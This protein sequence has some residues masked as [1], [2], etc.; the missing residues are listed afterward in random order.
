MASGRGG[1]GRPQPPWW[2]RGLP[3]LPAAAVA[4]VDAVT[5]DFGTGFWVCLGAVLAVLALESVSYTAWQAGYWHARNELWVSLNEAQL[6][7]L[8]PAEWIEAQMEKDMRNLS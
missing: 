3:V 5:G 1:P 7:G 8:S 4:L 2:R 6:R